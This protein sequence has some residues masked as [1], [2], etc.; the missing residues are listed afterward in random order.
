METTRPTID[1]YRF[2]HIQIAGVD[3]DRD[4]II[5]P[6][7]VQS[8]WWRERGHS[9]SMADLATVLECN[10]RVL[11]VGCGA[12]GR[13]TIPSGT[14]AQ[15]EQAGIELRAERTPRAVELFREIMSDDAVVAALHL[16]C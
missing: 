15:L 1:D 9:L 11:I 3:Y 4:V 14:R 13:M 10:P 2:G 8:D 16:T 7:H 5:F 6:D 12:N